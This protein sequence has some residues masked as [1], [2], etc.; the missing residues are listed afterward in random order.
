LVDR[1]IAKDIPE[2]QKEMVF[3]KIRDKIERY[4]YCDVPDSDIE[5]EVKA[6]NYDNDIDGTKEAALAEGKNAKIDMVLKKPAAMPDMGMV[7]GSGKAAPI[8][9]G[10]FF[11][12]FKG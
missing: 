11:D 5:D 1:I 12:G 2:D 4:Q 6:L 8:K 3:D 9:K 10:G 7:S